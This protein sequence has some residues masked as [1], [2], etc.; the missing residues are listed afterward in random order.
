MAFELETDAE[1]P[2][3]DSIYCDSLLSIVAGDVLK[4]LL[5]A[6]VAMEV[7]LTRLLVDVSTTQPSSPAKAS[8]IRKDGD[9]HPFG[10]KFSEWTEKLGLDPIGSFTFDGAPPKWHETALE[11]YKLRNGVAHGGQ[12]GISSTFHE[13]V[14]AMFSAGALLQYCRSQR[15]QLGLPVFSMPA[16]I[17]PWQQVMLC[18]D[19]HFSIASGLITAVLA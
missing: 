17:S 12:V 9:R 1:L 15:E 18:H 13:V 19:A 6:G 11:L 4:A 8:F 14:K 16:N 2:L 3:A 10:R 7:A 5:E